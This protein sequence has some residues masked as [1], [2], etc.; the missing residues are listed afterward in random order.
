MHSRT[1][2]RQTWKMFYKVEQVREGLN[3]IFR[4]KGHF[5]NDVL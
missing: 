5:L 3:A 1:E 4:R 2:E